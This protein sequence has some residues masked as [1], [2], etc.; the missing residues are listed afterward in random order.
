VQRTL[1]LKIACIAATGATAPIAWPDQLVPPNAPRI[2][3]S[4]GRDLAKVKQR[5][6]AGD[7]QL[8][9]T[10]AELRASADKEIKAGPFT[11]VHK[12]IPPPSGDKHDYVSMAPY[13]WPDPTKKDGLPYIRKDGRVN[14]EREGYDAPLLKK[15]SQAVGT[16][17]LA[18]HLSG[19][20]RYAAHASRLLRVWFLDVETRMNPH[21]NYAQFIPGVCEGRCYGIID[22]HAFLK[23]IDSVGMLEDSRDWTQADRTGMESWFRDY[24]RWLRTSKNGQQEAATKNN[25][26]SWYDVQVAT[27]ALFLGDRQIVRLLLEECKTKRIARQIEPD[28]RQPLELRRT[29]A[30]DYSRVNIDALFALATLGNQ[31]DVDLWHF[32]TR[33]RRSIRKAL[34]WLIPFATGEK[35]WEYEQISKLQGSSL[36]PLLRRAAVAYR[37]ER[38]ERILEKL[39]SPRNPDVRLLLFPNTR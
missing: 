15:I 34:D 21:L 32:E 6:A 7:G 1:L 5:I 12:R 25:H 26:G 33:D 13:F 29:K 22:G 37:D 3:L 10:L 18:Y 4:D 38:Y 24:L 23:V 39:A 8:A 35:K 2:F 17:A 31:V 36:V 14:P 28:G 11:V 16:L 20:E 9:A 27:C 19:D 30:F